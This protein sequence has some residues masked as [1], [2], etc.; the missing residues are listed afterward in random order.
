MKRSSAALSL[1]VVLIT[2]CISFSS[3]SKKTDPVP[4]FPQL[5]GHWS[6]TT[7]SGTQFLFWVNPVSG[8][9]YIT[10]YDLTVAT[11]AY[12]HYTGYNQGGIVPVT[13]KYFKIHLGTGTGGESFIE[14]TFSIND[15]TVNGTYA[16]YATGNT[17]DIITGTFSGAM[18]TK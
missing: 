6:A 4:D 1:F 8:V 16:V 17:T 15:M 2:L 13:N 5:I 12:Q 14:G 9:L 18:G 11:P 7:S 3:C 10:Q